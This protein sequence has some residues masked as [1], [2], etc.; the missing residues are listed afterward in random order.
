MFGVGSFNDWLGQNDEL[1]K[2][3]EKIK[4]FVDIFGM[5]YG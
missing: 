1:G 4:V 2:V 3:Y 5:V